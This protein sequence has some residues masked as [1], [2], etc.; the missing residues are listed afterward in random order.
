MDVK[1][2][3]YII[4]NWKMNKTNEEALQFLH[5][6]QESYADGDAHVVI[7]PAFTS[8][9]TVVE[10]LKGSNIEI[11]AQNC[12][13]A[14]SGA[15][16]GEISIDMIQALGCRYV[17]LGHSERRQYHAESSSI[18]GKK[19]ASV[20]K[21]SLIP[22]LCIGETLNDRERG[23]TESVLRQQL[24]ETFQE[25]PENSLENSPLLV[26]YEPVWA[27]GT[28][29]VATVQQAQDAHAF[30]RQ[31]LANYVPQAESL[32]IL[33][34]GSVKPD[35][36]AALLASKDINGALVGG[37]SLNPQHFLSIITSL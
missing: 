31:V 17:I 23:N 18:I 37:A 36:A 5:A 3:N 30:I 7:C 11:G 34:G 21:S 14:A 33:Y 6:F 25:L 9:S 4:A 8:L 24:E 20:L 15:Y 28:G 19:L 2:E 12:H 1:P 32:S 26:A 35:N 22:I 10:T 27:I 29:Q 13:A 16:T